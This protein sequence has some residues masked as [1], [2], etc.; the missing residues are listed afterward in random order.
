M[1]KSGQSLGIETKSESVYLFDW[2]KNKPIFFKNPEKILPLASLTK[3]MTALVIYDQKPNWDSWVKIQKSDER[4]SRNPLLF[5][6][7]EVKRVD[8][9]NLMLIASSNEATIALIRSLGFSEKEFT[10]LMNQ[11]AKELGL[12]SLVFEEPTGLNSLNRGSAREIA[13]L[14]QVV[15]Q[16]PKVR[17][18]LL[19]TSCRFT[20]RGQKTRKAYATNLLLTSFLNKSPYY[21]IGGK[22]GYL[23]ESQYNFVFAAGKKDGRE[24]IGVILGNPT[25][26]ERFQEMKSLIYWG[27]E[28]SEEEIINL[29]QLY[30]S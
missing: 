11:K 3:L 23:E 22:T 4:G 29:I 7:D 5:S 26:E 1:F 10:R 14:A 25:S 6:G 19:K 28:R 9:W 24:L 17:Q 27:L 15:F 13:R 2:Q 8:L 20:P 30:D 12:K 16:I 18:T 21:V